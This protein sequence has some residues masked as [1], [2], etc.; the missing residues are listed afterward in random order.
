MS[1]SIGTRLGTVEILGIIGRGGM[2][3]VYRA[4]DTKL[5]RDVAI[6]TLPDEFSHEP[7]RLSRFQ[8]E[9]EVLASLNHPNIAAIY[10]LQEAEGSRFLVLELVEGETLAERIQRGPIPI[11]EALQIARNICEALEAA[12]EQGVVH[13]DLKPANIKITPDGILKVLDFG[14]AKAI[15][16]SP[17]ASLSNSPT[18]I[19]MAAT[20]AG[21]VLGTA[22]YMSPEQAKGKTVDKRADIWAFGVVVYEMLTGKMPFF[23]ETVSETMAFVITKEPDWNVLPKDLPLRIRELLRRCLIKDP[24]NRI[25]DM[26]DVRI[27]LENI[28]EHEDP[29]P[30]PASQVRT[31][32]PWKLVIAS[33]FSL[34]MAVAIAGIITWNFRH[35]EVR[36]PIRFSFTLPEG[37]SFTNTGRPIVAISPDGKSIVYV[38]NQQLYLRAINEVGLRAIR[39]TDQTV[40]TPF[41]SPDGRWIAFY[42]LRDGKLKKVGVSGGVPVNL[43][44]VDN[45][46]GAAWAPDDQIY[47]GEGG[48]GI[49]RVPANGGKPETVIAVKSGEAAH[50]PQLLPNGDSV[51]FTLRTGSGSWDQSQILVQSLKSGQR[52]VILSGGADARYLST[53]HLVYAVGNTVFAVPFDPDKLEVAGGPVPIL[54]GISR[55]PADQTGAAHFSTS[56]EGSVAY[57]SETALAAGAS[58]LYLVDKNGMRKA[59]NIEVDAYYN[60]RISPDGKQLT[61]GSRNTVVWVYDLNGATPRRRLTFGGRDLGPLWTPDGQRIGFADQR[62]GESTLSWQRADGTGTVERLVKVDPT[63]IPQLESWTPDGKTAIFTERG[64]AGQGIFTFSPGTDEKPKPLLP[65]PATN[66]SLSPDGT[67]FA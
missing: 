9:A 61:V 51:L 63:L 57:V 3:E 50:G 32:P 41:F 60:P 53:G 13:R 54:E 21:V 36:E 45:P 62:D 27:E 29:L 23:G 8:R 1:L 26:G 34:A 17:A 4:R 67:W 6:K 46:F 38:A 52:K 56:I 33:L 35:S 25:R 66:A 49:V 37:Q 31:N 48:G 28:V 64:G 22:A 42:S 30:A 20:N 43:G 18:L 59:L 40:T 24:R 58:N 5:K 39:G 14:L 47:I 44:D 16:H 12:H 7:D 55:P 19:S 65:A 15:E 10:D 11:D 2:G